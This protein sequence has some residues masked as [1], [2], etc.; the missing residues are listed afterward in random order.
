MTVT[1]P[2]A[3]HPS[4]AAA[5]LVDGGHPDVE[6]IDVTKQFGD[7]TAVDRM[8]LSIARGTFYSLLGPSGCGKTTTLRMIAGFEQPTAGERSEERRVGKECIAVCRSRWSPY[9]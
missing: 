2:P 1:A 8:N 5:G 7:V 4:R 3:T 9:H 6:I